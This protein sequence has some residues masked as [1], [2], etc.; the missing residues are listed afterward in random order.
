MKKNQLEDLDGILDVEHFFQYCT[1]P[2]LS[3]H[4]PGSQHQQNADCIVGTLKILQ[5]SAIKL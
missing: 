3:P 1:S 5:L 2:A 4:F